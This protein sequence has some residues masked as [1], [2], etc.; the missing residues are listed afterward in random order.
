MGWARGVGS[1]C[2]GLNNGVLCKI[3]KL[4][5]LTMTVFTSFYQEAMTGEIVL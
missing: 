2:H 3:N 4:C 5:G 1:A